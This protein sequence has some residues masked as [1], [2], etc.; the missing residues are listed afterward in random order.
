MIN[1]SRYACFAATVS[2]LECSRLRLIPLADIDA[3]VRDLGHKDT[4]IAR[5]EKRIQELELRNKI[6]EENHKK[7][8]QKLRREHD[9]QHDRAKGFEHI[10]DTLSEWMNTGKGMVDMVDHVKRSSKAEERYIFL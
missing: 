7:D 10:I 6:R 9:R 5:L 8:Q 3:L 4:T 1:H 2:L